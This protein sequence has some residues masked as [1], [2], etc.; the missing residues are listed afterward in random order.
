MT[1]TEQ[2]NKATYEGN[3]ITTD[4]DVPFYFL[5]DTHVLVTY[6]N[7]TN[8]ITCV[9]N[10]DYTITGAGQ[11]TGGQ[12]QLLVDDPPGTHPGSV[13]TSI[14]DAGEFIAVTRD[15]PQTQELDYIE[16]ANFP[17]ASHELA[18]D[19]LTM[20]VQELQEKVDRSFK[21]PI[22]VEPDVDYTMPP[23]NAGKGLM[24][25]E[26]DKKFAN[27]DDN[28]NGI[29]SGANAAKDAAE[30]A[31]SNA[32]A[33]ENKANEWAEKT[34][35][36]VE[37]GEYSAKHWA[38]EA[39]GAISPGMI[40]MWPMA[41]PPVGWLECDGTSLDTTVEAALFNVLGYTY[42]GAGANF[43]IPDL[44]GEFVRGWDHGAGED[45]DVGSR[46][47]RGDGT[48]GDNVGTKQLDAI[49]DHTHTVSAIT[50]GSTNLAD[51]G[52][53][54]TAGNPTTSNHNGRSSTETRARNVNMMFII[55]T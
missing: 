9:L 45:P 40:M 54:F 35:G 1:V 47:D 49:Q 32:Q 10:Q 27:T 36:P 16:N 6:D 37:P 42:G 13:F 33:S 11:Q 17:A 23:Y 50:S 43:N 29:L 3:G 48:V 44:R 21:A 14:P 39:Q 52:V 46:T 41:T 12:I 5:E 31:A 51:P 19:K 15:V 26:S 2:T 22:I 38:Q 8:Q 7:G 25:D 24:W 20:Q 55:K 4:F 34:D 18:L 30:T 28:I 53:G